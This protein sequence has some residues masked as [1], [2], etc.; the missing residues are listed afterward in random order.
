MRAPV[1]V[2]CGLSVLLAAP[3]AAKDDL[4]RK[5]AVSYLKALDGSGNQKAREF[6]LGG[7][8]LTAEEV[9]I[10]EWQ[11]RD[12]IVQ[13]EEKDVKGAVE[14]MKG[15]D[16]AGAKALN[17]IMNVAES[18]GEFGMASVD[19]DTANK[20]MVPTQKAAKKFK[21][22]YPVFAYCARAG[23]EIYWHPAN[24]WREVIKKLGNRGKYKLEFHRFNVE[25]KAKD[26]STR[27]W[28]LRVLR[29]TAGDYDSGWKILP[30]SDWDPDW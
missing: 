24:P 25:E 10:P 15:L 6:L 8:T 26:G 22:K 20:M 19:Q 17:D 30:A 4:P 11:I 1:A 14:M 5:I 9:G 29:I 27:V 7:L 3:L 21:E 23:K 16:K 18:T 2:A 28:P 13:V 12:R